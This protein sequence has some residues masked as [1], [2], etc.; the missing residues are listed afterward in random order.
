MKETTLPQVY[1]PFFFFCGTNN[2]SGTI[3]ST[4]DLIPSQKIIQ[5][6]TVRI[7]NM[8]WFCRISAVSFFLQ[9]GQNHQYPMSF[10]GSVWQLK[11]GP[12]V[13]I[14]LVLPGRRRTFDTHITIPSYKNCPLFIHEWNGNFGSVPW[15]TSWSTS[16]LHLPVKTRSYLCSASAEF[17]LSVWGSTIRE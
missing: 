5:F 11:H 10:A 3:L 1:S 16:M 4:G 6:R 15:N 14:K 12:S 13:I 7:R 17:P 9:I 2:P 8:Q